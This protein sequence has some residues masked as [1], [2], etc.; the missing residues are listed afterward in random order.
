MT[1]LEVPH[2]FGKYGHH[3]GATGFAKIIF[4][5]NR[6]SRTAISR[7]NT[8]S[9]LLVQR[10]LYPDT[11]L[12][13]MAHVYLMSSSG[14][15]LQGDRFEIEIEAEANTMARITTQSA[16]KIYKMDKGYAFQKI[17]INANDG[18]YVEFVPRQL[19]PFKSSRFCQDV[20][21]SASTGSTVMYSE[22]VSAGRIASGE[23]FDFDA[24][25]LRMRVYDS[26]SRLL[27]SDVC[28][29][30]PAQ[31]RK[32]T[33]ERLFGGKSIWSTVY[34]VTPKGNHRS[35][36]KEIEKGI[37]NG[38]VLAGRSYLPNDCGLIVRMLDN[39]IDRIEEMISLVTKIVRSHAA[40]ANMNQQEGKEA[41]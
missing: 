19:I 14:G 34:V 31:D 32:E 15:I 20:R 26:E 16:T 25:F 29:I 23:N 37:N 41:P 24:C 30:D 13:R 21:I 11:S 35:M 7:L 40:K 10:A 38:P 9:P 12:P 36:D 1:L 8:Q 27:F 22:T 33:F 6:T 5:C 18:S 39:S 3:Q 28:N 2:H 4:S 17:N